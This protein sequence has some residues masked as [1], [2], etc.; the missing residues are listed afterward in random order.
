MDGALTPTLSPRE[1][2]LA[3]FRSE[4][5]T[6]GGMDLQADAERSKDQHRKPQPT[7]AGSAPG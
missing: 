4:S 7:T 2:G 5:L 1:R 6:A 3:V